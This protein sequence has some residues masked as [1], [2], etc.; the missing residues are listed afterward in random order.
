MNVKKKAAQRWAKPQITSCRIVVH[1]CAR[2]AG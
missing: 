2:E 1:F